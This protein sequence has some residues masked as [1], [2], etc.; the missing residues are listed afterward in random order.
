MQCFFEM[1]NFL[2]HGN[3][4]YYFNH[5]ISLKIIKLIVTINRITCSTHCTEKKDLKTWII[6][7]SYIQ[8]GLQSLIRGRT[9]SSFITM[10]ASLQNRS[11][12]KNVCPVLWRRIRLF[13]FWLRL[14]LNRMQ[15]RVWRGHVFIFVHPGT[16]TKLPTFRLRCTVYGSFSSRTWAA[17]L[18]WSCENFIPCAHTQ[19]HKPLMR[20]YGIYGSRSSHNA[21]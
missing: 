21:H 10:R 18:K 12:A 14:S 8:H 1:C 15:C 6:W 20:W 4:Y 2:Y 7:T 19:A 11:S 3:Y 5:T 17:L 13:C 16:P 9:A